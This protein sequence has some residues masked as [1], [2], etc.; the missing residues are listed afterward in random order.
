MLTKIQFNLALSILKLNTIFYLALEEVDELLK[1]NT[2]VYSFQNELYRYKKMSP[3]KLQRLKEAHP[4]LRTSYYHLLF[5]G[6]PNHP[7]T[8]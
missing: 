3:S 7:V 5:K 1:S 2:V 8:A 4:F 6:N